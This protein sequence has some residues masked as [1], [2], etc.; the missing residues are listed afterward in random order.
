LVVIGDGISDEE[1]A[2]TNGCVFIKIAAPA[3]LVTA[4]R[5]LERTHV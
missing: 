3:D 4:A 1:A 2:R 5:Q